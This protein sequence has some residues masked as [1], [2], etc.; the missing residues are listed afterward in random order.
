MREAGKASGRR[1]RS[2]PNV[3]VNL[4]DTFKPRKCYTRA[5]VA[6]EAKLPERKLRAAAELK[7]KRPERAAKERTA[8]SAPG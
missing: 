5:E 7:R 2:E 6:K 3:S 1:R 4:S 8:I